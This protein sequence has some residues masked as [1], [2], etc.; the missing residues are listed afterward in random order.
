MIAAVK[1]D[2]TFEKAW[3]QTQRLT[4]RFL[5]NKDFYCSSQYSEAAVRADFIDKFLKAIGWDV[6]HEI[7]HDPYRQEVKVEKSE[8]KAKGRADYAF[9]LTP[10][11]HRVRFFLEAKRPQ[12]D[13]TS[14]DN[15]FQ[16]MRYSW[17]RNLPIA[18][19]SDF[20]NF[21]VIDSR[22][23]PNINSARERIVVSWSCSD[24]QNK[25]KFGELY[26]LISRVNRELRRTQLACTKGCSSPIFTICV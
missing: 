24:F 6:D 23:R 13:I 22:F 7:Q 5:D 25:E 3:L 19:L 14:S 21:H 10:N 15:C 17:P 8:K 4:E 1:S 18:I 26:W 11:F 2:S 16:T 12:T 9:F 20:N